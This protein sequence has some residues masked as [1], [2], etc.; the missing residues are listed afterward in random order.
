ML[1][2]LQKHSPG[3]QMHK[4][5]CQLIDTRPSDKTAQGNPPW[6]WGNQG[7]VIQGQAELLS[8]PTSKSTL[9]NAYS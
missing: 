7:C 1:E 2:G 6:K 8:L 4:Q 5:G 3:K 9:N